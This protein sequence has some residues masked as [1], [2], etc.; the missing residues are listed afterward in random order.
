[1]AA[2][3]LKLNIIL[4]IKTAGTL[5]LLSFGIEFLHSALYLVFPDELVQNVGHSL[6]IIQEDV[7]LQQMQRQS[8]ERVL[9]LI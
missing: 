8:L 4:S 7:T 9:K 2:R 1:M 5:S 3:I 6:G